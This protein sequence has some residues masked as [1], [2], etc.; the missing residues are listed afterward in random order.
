MEDPDR[1]RIKIQRDGPYLVSGPARLTRTAIVESDHG[2]PVAWAEDQ[3]IPES[4]PRFVLCRCG[5]SANKPF[6]DGTH[7]KNG[8][9]G[10][11]T[12]D[13]A[14]RETRTRVFEGEDVKMSDDRSLCDHSG[15]CGDRNIDVWHMI[16]DTADP[17]VRERVIAMV[18]LCPSGRLTVALADGDELALEPAHDP[19]IAVVTDGALWV[20]GGVEIVGADGEIYEVRNRVTLCRCGDSSNKPFCDGTHSDNGFRD[21][22]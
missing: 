11:E 3:D 12:A 7:R 18:R 21:P 4:R 14:P 13:R 19:C 1:P 10:T 16:R 15:F 17:E 9:D 2:E 6:C 5:G 8:F 22:V 20:R